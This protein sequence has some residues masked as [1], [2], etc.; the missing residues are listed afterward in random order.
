MQKTHYED[1][2][3]P[4]EYI[5]GNYAWHEKFPYETFLLY[6]FGDVRRP[7]FDKF[8]DKIALDFA[9][10]PGRMV[11]RMNKFFERVDGCDLAQRLLDEAKVEN[12]NSQFYLTNGQDLGNT[13]ENFYD[14][15]Y[16]TISM[17]HIASHSIREKIIKKMYSSLKSGGKI[18][19]QMAYNEDCPY[20]RTNS[21]LVNDK[22]I[23]VKYRINQASY[24][25]DDVSAHSTNGAWDV[26]IGEDDLVNLKKDFTDIFG[27]VKVWCK[28]LKSL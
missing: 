3:I 11:K 18:T 16:C 2:T 10:G 17:Q 21:F 22:K 28:C 19:L 13:E 14:F 26:G 4:S 8:D 27:N 25:D 5:V 9:C 20:V 15:I 6:E 1:E 23:L 12:P 24:L 7:I